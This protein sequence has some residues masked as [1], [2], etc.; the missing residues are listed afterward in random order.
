MKNNRKEITSRN[1]L[2]LRWNTEK[3]C[4]INFGLKRMMETKQD[5]LFVYVYLIFLFPFEK[6]ESFLCFFFLTE[7][8]AFFYVENYM[9]KDAKISLNPFRQTRKKN[10]SDG[11]AESAQHF[12]HCCLNIFRFI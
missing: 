1:E 8:I 9:S 7:A 11:N 2:K 5:P 10:C 4:K 3:G 12:H 6:Q